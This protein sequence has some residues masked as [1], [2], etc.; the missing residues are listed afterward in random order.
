MNTFSS[1]RSFILRIR[2]GGSLSPATFEFAAQTLKGVDLCHL[3]SGVRRPVMTG[4]SVTA[5]TFIH[6]G[7]ALACAADSIMIM[8]PPT[9]QH[10]QTL[11]PPYSSDGIPTSFRILC[12]SP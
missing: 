8:D 1:H 10:L 12:V 9:L 2:L 5:T 7:A 11:R 4:S 6:N 3:G